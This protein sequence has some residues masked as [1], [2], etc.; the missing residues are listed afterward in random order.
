T[1]KENIGRKAHPTGDPIKIQAPLGLPKVPLSKD[2]QPTEDSIAL[3]RKLFYDVK[4]SGDDSLS[5]AGCHNPALH[6]ADGLPVAKG[7]ETGTRNT[8]T[9]LNA[10]YSVLQFWDGRA[11][12]LEQQAGN[13]I[14]N[15]KEMNL[16]HEVCLTRLNA[17]QAYKEAFARA[18]GPGVITMDKV[19]QAIAGFERTLLSG[20]SPFDR[21]QYGGDKSA[22]SAPAIRGLAIF[23]DRSRGNCVTCH[24][25]NEKFALFTDGK[26]HNIGAGMN[27]N[28]EL[29]DPGRQ[30]VTGAESDRGRFRTPS[31]RNVA[32]T[33]PYM[34][35]GS[36]KTLK[37]VVDFYAGGANSN[38]QLDAENKATQIIGAG[39]QRPR[40]FPR[41]SHR[42]PAIRVG[43]ACDRIV[44][45]ANTR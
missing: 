32:Q 28:G 18:F 39:S 12:S 45:R 6:F 26:F 17:D 21:Y 16:P 27:S 37:E 30:A 24:T 36:L 42:R 3:G 29:T 34:H 13:P 15:P 35:D 19:E 11:A 22:L 20:N 10:A 31:L 14:A 1:H 38:P 8:P 33:A 43:T 5:C 23:T 2:D 40:H 9:L 41:I 7:K 4:L 25:I 44:D